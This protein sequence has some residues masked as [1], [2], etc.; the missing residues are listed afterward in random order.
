MNNGIATGTY[1]EVVSNRISAGEFIRA[2]Y[3]CPYPRYAELISMYKYL[4]TFTKDDD[5]FK[6]TGS[7]H[8][9]FTTLFK[10]YNEIMIALRTYI[11]KEP[12][13]DYSL[14]SEFGPLCA[15]MIRRRV[16]LEPSTKLFFED[17]YNVLYN[18]RKASLTQHVY[19]LATSIREYNLT[20]HVP[21]NV[22]ITPV[23]P[24]E[25]L[26]KK[27]VDGPE[28]QKLLSL[29][30]TAGTMSIVHL[31]LGLV[32]HYSFIANRTA[33][34]SFLQPIETIR[35]SSL[36]MGEG[37]FGDGSTGGGGSGGG[38]GAGGGGGGVIIPPVVTPG[39][40]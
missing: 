5:I 29:Y 11:I 2:G 6:D 27:I 25:Q 24:G 15:E 30:G 31:L 12:N 8:S 16:A 7:V 40:P 33:L 3:G 19:I 23:K 22:L 13:Y 26:A 10:L 17:M 32:V 34:E 14:A 1:G 35:Y 9:F 18:K 39:H 20:S 38:G 4:E 36:Y 37:E 21:L 28:V